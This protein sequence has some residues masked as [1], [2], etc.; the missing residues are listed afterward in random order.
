MLRLSG[1]FT[2]CRHLRPPQGENI[3]SIIFGPVLMLVWVLRMCVCSFICRL[4]YVWR[5]DLYVWH[6][7]V[8]CVCSM[9][10]LYGSMCV[11]HSLCVRCLQCVC[12][13]AGLLRGVCGGG[14]GG[15]G[16]RYNHS[17]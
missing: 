8:R 3:P 17:N 13:V 12:R 15:W 5:G 2:P 10:G 9:S 16:E 14:V 7:C 11:W 1:G 4:W 6:V